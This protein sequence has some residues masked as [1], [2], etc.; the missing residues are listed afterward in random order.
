MGNL[1]VTGIKISTGAAPLSAQSRTKVEA[2]D[3]SV[4][5]ITRQTGQ[6]SAQEIAALTPENTRLSI[7]RDETTGRYV[8]KSVDQNTGE[9]IQQ[10][11]TEQMLTQIARLR[12][13]VGLT[14]DKDV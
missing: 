9:V 13:I 14:V 11:P 6:R 4:P 1:S 10:Y 7:V 5:A 3:L 8:F 2:S 12:Q